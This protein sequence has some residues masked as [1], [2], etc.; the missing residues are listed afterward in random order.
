MTAR[1]EALAVARVVAT[2]IA[3]LIALAGCSFVGQSLPPPAPSVHQQYFAKGANPLRKVAIMPFYPNFSVTRDRTDAQISGA[4]AADLLTRFFTDALGGA[5]VA[6]IPASD[7]QI[8][9]EARGV[10]PPRL[11]ASAVARVVS[12]EFGATS[13]VVGELL[14][15]RERIGE[16]YGSK[17]AASVA[18]QVTLHE[19]PSGFKLWSGR[20]DETQ[21]AL[22]E[23]LSNARRYPGGGLRWLTS[24]EIAQWGARETATALANRP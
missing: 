19:A 23:H 9:F 1:R 7:L 10:I 12:E 3:L 14:R 15:Y 6:T 4:E 11:D 17:R 22:T 16:W 20:F 5:G 8:A 13:V 18:F 21:H 24:T 2:A